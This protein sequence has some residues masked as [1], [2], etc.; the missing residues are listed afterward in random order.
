MK[1]L[2]EQFLDYIQLELGLSENTRIAYKTDLTYF[3]AFL[4]DRKIASIQDA[5]RTDILDFMMAERLRGMSE[6]SVVRELVTL[7]VFFR[8]LLQEGEL[9]K[10]EAEKMESPKLWKMLPD[11][12][13]TQEV[14][15]LLKAPDVET[16][17]GFRDNAILQTFY[18]TGM[19]VSELAE[20]TID[21]L[22]FDEGYIRCI[23]KGKK[24]R[25][26]PI[27][28]AASETVEK[29]LQKVRPQYTQ[30]PEQRVVFLS[31]QGKKL[32]RKTLWAMIKKYAIQAGITKNI[33]PHT[34]RHSF[35]SHLLENGA[36]LRTIQEM[37][38]HADIGTT[39]IYTHV[40]HKRL[41]SIH[42]QF[43]PRA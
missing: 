20:I 7:K 12:L 11:F 39:Q 24:E 4:H 41:K 18:A 30:D 13:S 34:L 17:L 27:A 1:K 31:K 9:E 23:G 8:Y 19:R 38:G 26:I 35:A 42:T 25:V 29:Y 21:G 6:T 36:D 16:S 33:Y 15:R 3:I 40:E 2:I 32:S 5:R 22:Y 14:E 10:N 28:K 37:L 43:H